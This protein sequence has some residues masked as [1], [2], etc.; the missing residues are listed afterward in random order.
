MHVFLTGRIQVGKSTVIRRYLESWP[1]L[2]VGGFRTVW[3]K[4][5]NA[6]ENSIHIV[7]ACGGAATDENRVGLRIGT[8]PNRTA[9]DFPEVFDRV[10]VPLLESSDGSDIIIMDEIGAGENKSLLFQREVLR[11]LDG[12]IPV[13]G[14]V[15]DRPGVLPELVRGH[16]R[17]EIIT[18][19]EENREAVFRRL[20]GWRKR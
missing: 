1:E 6:E 7:R 8:Y 14:V 17:T 5:R 9:I 19:T 2:R 3:K 13:L 10:G 16:R 4:E 11:R 20:L 12:D 18:V 15:R